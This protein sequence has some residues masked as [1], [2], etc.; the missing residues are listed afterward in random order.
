[1]VRDPHTETLRELEYLSPYTAPKTLGHY[2]EPAGGQHEQCEQLKKKIE[3]ITEF[4][5]K[6]PL[7]RAEAWTYYSACCVPAV[8]YPLTCSHMSRI[9]LE[10]VQQKAMSVIIPRCGFNRNTHRSISY[11]P[12]GL[13]GANFCHLYVEQGVQQITNFLRHW[14]LQS[15]VGKLL[16]CV[17][18][19]LQVS[20]GVSYP[21][22]DQPVRDLPHIEAMG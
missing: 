6:T 1:M 12:H 15:A 22:L 2:K 4:L 19:W 11:G 20:L 14:R 8:C 9:Q 21:V 10:K 7:T 13:R 18:T 16:K 17:L 5:W 3:S